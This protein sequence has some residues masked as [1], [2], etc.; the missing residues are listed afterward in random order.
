MYQTNLVRS[1]KQYVYFSSVKSRCCM[2]DVQ[3]PQ[4]QQYMVCAMMTHNAKDNV[5]QCSIDVAWKI[6]N[7]VGACWC[8]TAPMTTQWTSQYATIEDFL[9]KIS[10]P[11]FV[12]SWICKLGTEYYKGHDFGLI[13][14]A[15][16][17]GKL[18]FQGIVN[19]TFPITTDCQVLSQAYA[20]F[21]LQFL[22]NMSLV[23]IPVTRTGLA[24]LYD[25]E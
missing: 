17:F 19:N 14:Q 9:H 25:I 10:H 18:D 1:N 24:S 12:T 5:Q 23:E 8:H 4:L 13:C 2:M 11:M 16:S 6:C 7:V 20:F 21:H 15:K 22:G 3:T